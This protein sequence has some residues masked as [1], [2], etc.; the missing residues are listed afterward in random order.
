MMGGDAHLP[1]DPGDAQDVGRAGG[2]EGDAGGDDD[3][4]A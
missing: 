2:A 1:V 4:L 3:A